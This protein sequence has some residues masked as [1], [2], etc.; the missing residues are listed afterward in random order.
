M[1]DVGGMLSEIAQG[2]G[3][4]RRVEG[5]RGGRIK[6]NIKFGLFNFTLSSSDFLAFNNRIISKY[7]IGS[8]VEGSRLCLI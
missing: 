6:N 8:S 1:Y 3:L 7:R 5:K 4:C 2:C